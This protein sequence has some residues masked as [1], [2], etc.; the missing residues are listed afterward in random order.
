M[1]EAQV[2]SA[3]L[4]MTNAYWAIVCFK[5]TNRLMSRNYHEY[6]GATKKP[7]KR[8]RQEPEPERDEF[9]ENQAKQLNAILHIT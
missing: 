2:L 7:A 3:L 6:V 8:D 5:L 9:A 4:L 1:T